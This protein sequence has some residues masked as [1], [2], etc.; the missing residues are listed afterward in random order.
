MTETGNTDPAFSIRRM[1]PGDVELA[2]EWAAAEGWNPGRHDAR[3]FF[4]ADPQGFFIG[5]QGGEPVGC[6]SAVAYG[7]GFGFIGLYIVK[8]EFRGKGLGMR[9]WEAGMA[10]LGDRNIGL[11]GVVA[12]QANYRR[13]GFRLAYRN[14]R[15]EGTAQ[16]SA[17]GG[18]PP[19]IV[20]LPAVPFGQLVDYDSLMFSAPRPAFL[21]AWCDQ[22]GA[23]A[24]GAMKDGGLRGYGVLRPCRSGYKIG[25]LFAD[26]SATAA[27][28]HDALV[29]AVPGE[30]VFLDVPEVNAAAV[31]LAV[32]RDMKSVFETARMYTGEPPGVPVERVYGVT[33]FELG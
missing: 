8:P 15:F 9:L 32:R 14:I 22:P 33:T 20:E 4:A 18:A 13:S 19:G 25:P 23:V 2:L 21:R 30:T 16:G 1:T 6:V 24:R 27:A 5:E 28:L 26:E 17:G 12:Q 10:Y 7:D 11:D 29:A 3:C 31:A